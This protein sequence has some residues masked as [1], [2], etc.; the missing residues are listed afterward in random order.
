VSDRLDFFYVITEYAKHGI[1]VKHNHLGTRRDERV[2]AFKTSRTTSRT[3][4]FADG[5]QDALVLL[6]PHGSPV[7]DFDFTSETSELLIDPR[8]VTS[9]RKLELVAALPD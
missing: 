9:V 1:D 2:L 3:A 5:V 4:Y 8:T 6:R 7:P